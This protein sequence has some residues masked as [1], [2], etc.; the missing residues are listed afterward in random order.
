MGVGG[1]FDVL[2]GRTKR[3]PTWMQRIG[4]EWFYRLGQE[5]RR[6]WKRYLVTNTVY[7][8]LLLKEKFA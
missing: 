5:P 6:M 7:A 8:W 2:A 1:T 4:L 3:A